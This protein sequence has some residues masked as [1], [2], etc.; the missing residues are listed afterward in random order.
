MQQP[1]SQALFKRVKPI[2][3]NYLQHP[4][5][6]GIGSG[7]LDIEK[8][9][10][11][12]L[13]DYVYL[14]EYSRLF[15]IGASKANTLKTMGLFANL[16]HGTLHFEMDLH[17]AYAQRLGISTKELESTK[18]A[19]TTTAYTS[20][21]LSQASLGGLE[22]TVAAVLTCAWSYNYIGKALNDIAGANAHPFYGDWVR[23]YSSEEFSQLTQ[24]C[25]T[26]LDEL[27][28]N[29][30]KES[31]LSLEEIVVTTS[32]YE[33]MFWDMAQHLE[34]WPLKLA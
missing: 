16:L 7:N 5:V 4:F 20:Y 12:M 19:A 13:Q 33:Y 29:R 11:Y 2:W 32:K 14:I 27:T 17:R 10:H 24:D 26:L 15:A 9:K 1:F 21:M 3:D 8:F 28:A 18:P 31:L 34:T 25:I 22:N 30:S 23:T 6:Q